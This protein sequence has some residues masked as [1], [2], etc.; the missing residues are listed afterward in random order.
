MKKF[1]QN[2]FIVL[3]VI[4]LPAAFPAFGQSGGDYDL[5]WNTIDGGGGVSSGGD[6]ILRGTIGQP[7]AGYMARAPHQRPHRDYELWGGF[8][9]EAPFCI[10]D[11]YHF[12]RFA[13]YWL[14]TGSDLPADLYEDGIV[15]PL[16]LKLFVDEWLYYCPYGWPLR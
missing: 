11:F 13:E 12:A 14:E 5:S 3:L 16:D 15:N 10:V 6:Y 8:W 4:C 2:T 1:F 9:A 7:D